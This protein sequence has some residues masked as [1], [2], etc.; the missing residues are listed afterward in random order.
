MSSTTAEPIPAASS[1]AIA[2]E[3]RALNLGEQSLQASRDATKASKA[4]IEEN[5]KSSQQRAKNSIEAVLQQI[6]FPKPPSKDKPDASP[7]T[8]S[9]SNSSSSPFLKPTM[10][11]A[12]PRPYGLLVMLFAVAIGY[13]L[14]LE[15][16]TVLSDGADNW[17]E[18][19]CQP[20]IMPLASLYGHD[21]NENL[22]FCLNNVIQEKSKGA[23]G[24]LAQ[25]MGGFTGVLTNLMESA[26]SFRTTLATMVGG[27]IRLITE[28]KARMEALMA[29][30]KMT[31]SRM[32]M[33][34]FRVYGTMFSVVYMGMSAMT[35]VVNFTDTFVFGFLEI[36]CFPEE[37]Q[38]VLEGGL[39]KQIK[40][41]KVGEL[42]RGGHKVKSTY[43]FLGDGHEMV[44]IGSVTVSANHL[45][46]YEGKWIFSK[47]HPEAIPLGKWGGGI[48]KPLICLSTDTHKIPV[49][50]YM[51]TDYDETDDGDIA[52]QEFVHRSLNGTKSPLDTSSL[53]YD[54]GSPS[55]TRIHTLHGLKAL[56]QVQLGDFVGKS[57]VVG[58]QRS[59]IAEFCILPDGSKIAAGALLWNSEKEQWLRAYML[60]PKE[61]CTDMS[62]STIY[63]SL[64]LNPGNHYILEN[65]TIV[66]DALEV[67][68]KDTMKAYI[69]AL[70]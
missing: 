43:V 29:R 38:I 36:F 27:I 10:V 48:S 11:E 40:D 2:L 47:D 30:V 62:E 18:I 13:F 7:D 34:M 22:Q 14:Y 33:L 15:A 8:T 16:S 41:I 1:N 4:A 51:F 49:E 59:K 68:D 37:Q 50:N 35:A 25:G 5:K 23:V 26:N 39:R 20:H 3:K 32:K 63:I 46:L 55:S 45:L 56:D 31:A 54:I 42:L 66:R 70:L 21:T 28:F 58:I 57:K 53:S 19:R 65:G 44:Q 17:S 9:S 6:S 69:D 61:S 64:F 24:P 52:T 60:Y 12:Y 67:K